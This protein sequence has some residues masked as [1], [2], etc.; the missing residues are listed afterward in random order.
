MPNQ[1][2]SVVKRYFDGNHLDVQPVG[3][4]PAIMHVDNLKK[5]TAPLV[6]SQ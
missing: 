5:V 2:A 3:G 1:Q 6:S 4:S